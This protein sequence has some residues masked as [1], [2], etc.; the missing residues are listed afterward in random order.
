MRFRDFEIPLPIG[1]E[2]EVA[3][4]G[5]AVPLEAVA[6]GDD[7]LQ[8]QGFRR[9][10][11]AL[12]QDEGLGQCEPHAA[13]LEVDRNG[14]VQVP[15]AP[16]LRNRSLGIAR[17]E[18]RRP[19]ERAQVG[20]G[21]RWCLGMVQVGG[22][23]LESH[24]RNGVAAQIAAAQSEQLEAPQSIHVGESRRRQEILAERL[25]ELEPAQLKEAVN[26]FE[27]EGRLERLARRG[28]AL[29]RAEQNAQCLRESPRRRQR[30][31][32][33]QHVLIALPAQIHRRHPTAQVELVALGERRD[34]HAVDVAE[35]HEAREG[36]QREAVFDPGEVRLG[37]LL[38]EPRGQLLHG[39][40]G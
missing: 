13:A 8:L 12:A 1:H 24:D 6:L 10:D 22:D 16:Q 19:P 4:C 5:G 15:C 23:S 28:P 30:L 34:G 20:R 37:H 21:T 3:E 25:R 27:A 14:F 31:D 18:I 33:L 36:R 9:F 2:A 11:V 29:Q 40:E 32:L 35:G 38:R 7:Q 39:V 17:D 26:N